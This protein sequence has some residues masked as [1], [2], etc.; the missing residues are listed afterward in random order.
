MNE[1]VQILV[2]LLH[3]FYFQYKLGGYNFLSFILID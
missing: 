2:K 3:N 1:K